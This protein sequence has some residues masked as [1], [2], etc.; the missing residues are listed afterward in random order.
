[1]ENQNTETKSTAGKKAVR[2]FILMLC[3]PAVLLLGALLY[4]LIGDFPEILAF[5][6][7]SIALLLP[8]IGVI[9]CIMA[10]TKHKE[11]WNGE[12]SLAIITC[13]MC[14]PLFY[15]IYFFVCYVSGYGLA[16]SAMM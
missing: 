14:N 9:L 1:M 12:K 10:L 11:L 16:G 2:G 7:G 4:Q 5:I 15:F 13:V 6:F 3:G 8:L